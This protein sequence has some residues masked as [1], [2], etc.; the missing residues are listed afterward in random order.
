[1]GGELCGWNRTT[2]LTPYGP[3]LKEHR[4]LF[5]RGISTKR[6]VE[7]SHSLME[8]A[9]KSFASS[10]ASDSRNLIGQVHLYVCLYHIRGWGD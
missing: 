3:R 8:E 2:V 4:S 5:A 10:L 9:A 6:S 7:K 1:M